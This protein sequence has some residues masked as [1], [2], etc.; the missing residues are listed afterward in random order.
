MIMDFEKPNRNALINYTAAVQYH[1]RKKSFWGLSIGKKKKNGLIESK[2][3]IT[4]R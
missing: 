2:K 4:E 1:A 3:A